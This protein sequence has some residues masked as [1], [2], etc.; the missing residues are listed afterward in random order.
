MSNEFKET[1]N[2]HR[3]TARE[4]PSYRD[5]N[6]NGWALSH[7][8]APCC[9]LVA[10][11][12]DSMTGSLLLDLLGDSSKSALAP[13]PTSPVIP[14]GLNGCPSGSL[15]C[16]VG[17]SALDHGRQVGTLARPEIYVAFP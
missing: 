13:R 5:P 4:K 15:E 14:A 17:S 6:V 16:A 11:F 8:S 1:T 10:A 2:G 3:R 9:G 12:V 7:S